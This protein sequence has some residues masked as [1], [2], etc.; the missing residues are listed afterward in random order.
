MIISGIVTELRYIATI[1]SAVINPKKNLVINNNMYHFY[2]FST[3]KKL[4]V[5]DLPLEKIKEKFGYKFERVTSVN[6]KNSV[7]FVMSRIIRNF[8]GY[9]IEE[10]YQKVN[11]P[12][13]DEQ[14]QKISTSK[15][16]K[17]RPPE[18]RARIS[19]ALKGRSNFQ[20]K[21]HTEETRS[22]MAAAKMGNTHTKG[23]VWAHNPRSDEEVRVKDLKEIPV[24]Y[25]KGRDYYSTEHGL[26]YFNIN[27][28][29]D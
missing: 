24:G 16:G 9:S 5:S 19:A 15:L 1:A 18:V 25:S 20:G 22:K 4:I 26:Y 28:R 7:S 3:F 23:T 12:L 29:Q 17:P 11:K 6:D 27:R 10:H 14:R 8:P 2:N 13:T 21:T